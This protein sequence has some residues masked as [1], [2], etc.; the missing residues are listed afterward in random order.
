MFEKEEL[1]MMEVRKK[2][3]DIPVPD[4]VDQYIWS[5]IRKA[6]KSRKKKMA[7]LIPSLAVTMALLISVLSIRISPAFAS[8]VSQIPGFEKIVE[9][10]Q[11]D[12]GLKSALEN[13][14]YQPVGKEVTKGGITFRVDHIIIDEY[15]LI[16]LYSVKAD[17]KY[18][19]LLLDWQNIYDE[20]GNQIMMGYSGEVIGQIEAGEW[21]SKRID[22]YLNE[23][24]KTI[25]EQLKVEVSFY[26]EM[27][28]IEENIWDVSFDVDQEKFNK[29]TKVYEINKTATIEGHEVIFKEITIYPTTLALRVHYPE[30]NTKKIFSF[31][32]LVIVNEKGEEWA[33]INNGISSKIISDNEEIIFL[34]SNYFD[35]DKDD[36]LFI[37]FSS[38][39]AL[40]KDKLDVVVDL[41]EKKLVKKPDENL[42]LADF[43]FENDGIKLVFK[44]KNSNDNQNTAFQVI[45]DIYYDETG[46]E[47]FVENGMSF[48]RDK[49]HFLQQFTIQQP[50]Q[51][52]VTFQIANYPTTINE[53]VKLQIK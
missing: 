9:L 45:G 22:I 23:G 7:T 19:S 10:I 36:N 47:Y 18:I 15:Q 44:M 38:A 21:V 34:Q 32:D 41:S 40:D 35:F 42:Q 8:F 48:T 11:G 4:V 28:E 52:L 37:Q 30:T 14:Y 3:E 33:R 1:K 2:Y 16:L 25:P 17:E 53:F 6:R 26:S 29:N 50:R 12:K 43:I 20:K 5:G 49:E 31:E 51:G 46:N 27:E 24:I 13:E 39:K